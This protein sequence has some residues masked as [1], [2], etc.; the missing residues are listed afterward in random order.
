[1]YINTYAY[2][3]MHSYYI[4][5]VRV[6]EKAQDGR[7]SSALVTE[8]GELVHHSYKSALLYRYLT[9]GRHLVCLHLSVKQDWVENL[10]T[11]S[12]LPWKVVYT[13]R[14]ILQMGLLSVCM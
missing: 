11:M 14:I 10:C 3:H 8:L 5:N 12:F 9:S 13:W 4:W 1:M 2:V 7:H 6:T